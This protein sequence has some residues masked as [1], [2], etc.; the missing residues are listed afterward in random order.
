M[1]WLI[2]REHGAYGQ[3]AFPMLAALAAGDLS[4]AAV[5]LVAAFS[6]AFVAHESLLVLLGQRGVRAGRDQ[7]RDARRTLALTGSL[8]VVTA[9]GGTALMTAG[10]RWTVLVPAA[11]A[12]ATIPL[13]LQKTQ[14]TVAGEMHVALA[15]ASCALPVGTAATLRPQQAAACWFVMTLGFWG[16]TLAVRG[17][18][19]LQRRERT[20]ALRAGAICI[21]IASPPVAVVIAERFL[22]HP[23]LWTATMPLSVL[24]VAVAA[25]PPRAR[26]LRR[27]GWL[28]IGGSLATGVLLAILLSRDAPR[29]AFYTHGHATGA[30]PHVRSD[31]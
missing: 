16:A 17:V 4:T 14:K 9:L 3:L 1:A 25:V 20:A 29:P 7:G 6:S 19:A 23:L 22:V 11:F 18:I 8:A 24:A 10:Q 31:R 28:L 5:L 13:I 12:A 30:A 21:A 2:P 26:H 27:V 15:L